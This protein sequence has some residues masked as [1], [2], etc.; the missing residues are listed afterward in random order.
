MRIGISGNTKQT[1]KGLELILSLGHEVPFIFGLPDSELQNKV[2]SVNLTQFAELNNIH[3]I[4]TNNWEDVLTYDVDVIVSLGDSRY[5]PPFIIE[6]YKVIGNHGAVLPNVQGGASL[7]WAR[8]LNNGVW[9]VSL[10]ELDKKIDNGTILKTGTFEYDSNLD[11]A[12]FC[13]RCDDLTIEL[14]K[15]LLLNGPDKKEYRSSKIDIRVGK[16]IDSKLGT[17]L[18]EWALKHNLNIYMPPRTKED[19]LIKKEWGNEFI[20]NFKIANNNPYPKYF[21]NE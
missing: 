21:S 8:M 10:M 1:L 9:G 18:L 6:K 3:L 4:K 13:E 7:V 20:S 17:E 16:H 2:N 14:L 11:M 19:G 5:V 12:T 15:D